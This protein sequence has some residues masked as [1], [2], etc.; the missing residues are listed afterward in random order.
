MYS[1][2]LDSGIVKSSCFFAANQLKPH[3]LVVE[4][5]GASFRSYLTTLGKR[6]VIP[7]L[8]VCESSRTVIDGHHRLRALIDLGLTAVPVTFINYASEKVLTGPRGAPT[9][10]KEEI[11]AAATSGRLLPPKTSEHQIVDY[12]GVA[13]PLL[14]ISVLH[15]CER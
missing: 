9:I 6:F 15:E 11:L 5:R 1:I 4:D 13:H 8:L 7:S 2:V 14:L 12:F 10:S 3:E